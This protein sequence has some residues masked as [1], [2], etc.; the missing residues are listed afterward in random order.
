MVHR[1]LLLAACLACVAV[2]ASA[3]SVWLDREH[4]PSVQTEVLFP[5]FDDGDTEFPTWTW[6]VAGRFPVARTSAIVIEAPYAHGDLGEGDIASDGSIGNPYIGYEYR[7]HPSGLLLE[8]G[9]RMP[10]MEEELIPFVVGYFSDVDRQDA[11]VPNQLTLR[12][13]LHYHHAP[14]SDSRVS[15]DLRFVPLAWIK[16]GDTFLDENE[17]FLG[18]GGIV[19]YEGDDVRVGGGLAGRWNATNDGA[20]FGE[21]SFHQLDLEADFLHGAVRPG[22]QLKLPLDDNL[23]SVVDVT[24]GLSLTILP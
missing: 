4:R 19:R 10:L 16:T 21:A 1:F 5:S 22:V 3:Q 8:A 2:P 18:Y 7:P 9:A 24:W 17:F 13:G 12:L 6:F 11:F 14:G 20:D 15:Y 23:T